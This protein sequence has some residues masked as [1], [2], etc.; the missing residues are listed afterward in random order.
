ML[1]IIKADLYKF[2]K[3]KTFYVSLAVALVF[4]ILTVVG[5]YFFLQELAE[6]GGQVP[7]S[8]RG[9]VE[10]GR[11]ALFGG[12][13]NGMTLMLIAVMTSIFV[14]TDYTTGVI[15]DTVSSGKKRALI[16]LSKF[17]VTGIGSLLLVFIVSLVQGGLGAIMLDYGKEFNWSEVWLFLQT[18]MF[19]GI[20]ILALNAMFTFFATLLKTLGA[21]LGVNIGITMFG[22]L[23][24]LLISLIHEV[25]EKI[26]NYW[27]VNVVDTPVN[28]V[29]NPILNTDLPNFILVSLGY[30]VVFITASIFVFRRQDIK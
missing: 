28:E 15:K 25:V 17:I 26:G 16:Y 6:T 30:L 23:L 3:S 19:T 21:S 5:S 7:P 10:N 29:L 14:A 2:F 11:A 13:N 22:A 12:L 20:I 4:A 27:I 1:N 24:F 8:A 18:F 9:V